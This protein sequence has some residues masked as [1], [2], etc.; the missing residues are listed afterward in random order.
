MSRNNKRMLI[1]ILSNS[2]NWI[3]SSTLAKMLNV[4]ERTIRNYIK[5]INDDEDEIIESSNNGYRILKN[6]KSIENYESYSLDRTNHV[7]SKL[8]V[9]KD[10][11][12]IHDEAEELSISESTLMNIIIP[13]IKDQIKD[14]ELTIESRN[15]F[16]Y[17]IG[18]E[19]NKRKLIGHIV[20]NNS[21]GFF[22]SQ[23]TLENL[24][25]SFDVRSVTE[26]LYKTC[27]DSN[28]F[29]NNYALNNLLIHLLIIII[30][31]ESNQSLQLLE[32]SERFSKLLSSFSQKDDIVRLA[33]Q[34]STYFTK[35][36]G[37]EVPESD[38]QQMII[39][40]ALSID[41]E[42][43]N[44]E[45]IIEKEFIDTID[46]L[47]TSLSKRYNITD[48]D[49]DFVLQ[50]SLHM[51]N[52]KQRNSFQISYPNP[53]TNQIKKD[54]APIYDMAVYFTHEF[55]KR[56]NINLSEDE[57]AFVAFHLG[58]YLENNNR[59]K[60]NT[61]G[62]IVT[63]NYHGFAK[64]LVDELKEI[65]DNEIMILDVLPFDRYLFE[66]PNCDILITT[67]NNSKI[68]HEHKV[69]VNP[70]LTSRNVTEIWSELETINFN[71]TFTKS[72]EFL[73]SLFN[74]D[75][76]FRNIKLE[77]KKE[78][79]EYI[80]NKCIEL[81]YVT[82]QFINDVLLRESVSSTAFTDYLAVPHTISQFAE[83]SFIAVMHNDSQ[84]SWET[85][86]V[87]FIL[88]IGI[89]EQDMKYFKDAFDIIITLFNSTKMT[90][91]LLETKDFSSFV[92]KLI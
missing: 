16:Y 38:Y 83:Q 25:P 66:S 27:H 71:K 41:H 74:E 36:F 34:I 65:F 90:I 48:F 40:I 50:F 67:I 12:S 72:K 4:T 56:Y 19:K 29:L 24:F 45:D 81:G 31:I 92:S 86:N 17:L 37:Y 84:I 87:H 43:T 35:E 11:I 75:L 10:G 78:Y 14:F 89:T 54:Y 5:K 61:T 80:G 73:K 49:Q 55:S 1:Q 28:L 88:M 79:I 85:K 3:S 18:E 62:I 68:K 59:I 64:S 58:A 26:G 51:F 76:Y 52:A 39:L 77:N 2:D 91:E 82:D 9:A 30:R 8:L 70:I 6:S 7:L 47:L 60:T 44:L 13:Q 57:I 22:T 42:I 33:V 20:T 21:Y 23:E 32:S 53:I 15:Y 46:S 69:L 63:E